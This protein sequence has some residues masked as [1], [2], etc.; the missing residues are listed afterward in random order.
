[1]I[2]LS[3]RPLVDIVM[4]TKNSARFLPK[5]IESIANQTCRS[6]RLIVVDGGSLDQSLDIVGRHPGALILHQQGRGF[7]N[8]WNEGI[9]AG[10]APWVAFLDSDDIWSPSKL[11]LQLK[12]VERIPDVEF[13]FGRVAFF[14]EPGAQP[15]G[16]HKGVIQRTHLVPMMGAVLVRRTALERLGPFAEHLTISGD[17]EWIA[18]LRDSCKAGLTDEVLLYKRIHTSSLG[19]ATA[20]NVFT[21]ELMTI[22]RRRVAASRE[23]RSG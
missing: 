18:N 6:H 5:A 9:A 20:E 19:Q 10:C 4:A 21:Q 12:I 17:L 15:N 7:L 3:S 1:M 22:L 23:G 13:V 8:A 2:K 11:Q 16:F 14:V